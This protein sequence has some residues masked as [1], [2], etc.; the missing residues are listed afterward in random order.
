MN[1]WIRTQDRKVLINVSDLGIDET[2]GRI[3]TYSKSNEHCITLG[4][5]STMERLLE[6][7]N[8]ISILLDGYNKMNE[9]IGKY[10]ALDLGIKVN[11]LS[12]V[13]QMPKK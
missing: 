10:E 6:I 13:Y 1:L 12:Y 7:L 11:M 3:I 4:Y 5:Y 9:K 8:E 2:K